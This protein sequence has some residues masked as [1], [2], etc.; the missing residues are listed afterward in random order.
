MEALSK[1]SPGHLSAKEVVHD[2][3]GTRL[4]VS[5]ACKPFRSASRQR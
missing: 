3:L 2:I 5:F 1:T 4:K